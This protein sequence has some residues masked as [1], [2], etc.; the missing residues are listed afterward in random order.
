[1]SVYFVQYVCVCV[2]L[3]LWIAVQLESGPQI[4]ITESVAR[5]TITY[6]KPKGKTAQ[7]PDV[8]A[9]KPGHQKPSGRV[10]DA[11]FTDKSTR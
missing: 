3:L 9:G 4:D 8:N 10:I 7:S 5:E 6:S 1:M 11:T 2:L